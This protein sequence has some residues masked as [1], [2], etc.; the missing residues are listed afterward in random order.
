MGTEDPGWL[1]ITT[2]D[3]TETNRYTRQLVLTE[4]NGKF[5]PI[6]GRWLDPVGPG[7]PDG[8]YRIP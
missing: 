2:D 3:L 7:V 8:R 4:R 5:Y 1:N 6:Q